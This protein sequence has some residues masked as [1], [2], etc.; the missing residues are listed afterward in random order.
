MPGGRDRVW[1]HLGDPR[2]GLEGPI[3]RLSHER[4]TYSFEY[5]EAWLAERG[6]FAIDPSLPVVPGEVFSTALPGIFDDSA[7][8]RW[9]RLLLDRREQ[10]RASQSGRHPRALNDWDYLLG[11]EDETRMGGMRLRTD[12]GAY[13]ASETYP[14]P[15]I[16][17]LRQME[18]LVRA[19]ESGEPIPASEIDALLRRLISP[20]AS[21]GGAR[22]KATFRHPNGTLWLA[23][24]PSSND[25]RDMGG[26]EYVL[27]RLAAAAGVV[28][29]EAEVMKLNSPYHSFLARRFDREGGG[30]RRLFAS[31]MTL[32]GKADMESASY[33]DIAAA[34]EQYGNPQTIEDDLKQLYRRLVF[35]VCTAHRDDHLRNHGFVHDGRGWR[36]APAYDL[37]PMPE[38]DLHVLALDDRSHVPSLETLRGTA[39]YYRLS[40]NAAAHIIS[41]VKDAVRLWRGIAGKLGMPVQAMDQMKSAFEE[42]DT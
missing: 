5:S 10:L 29:P 17:D 7:P 24:F 32:T 34:Q 35:N 39:L 19:V 33:L 26:W 14:I 41:D 22:P 25:R 2:L 11:I 8:D 18:H 27:N 36:P 30:R 16:A 28:V 37:N 40:P 38:S 31:A 3:G 21:L 13:L 9:G 1:V 12:S 4:G 6:N 20:G 23:K 15:P 42:L